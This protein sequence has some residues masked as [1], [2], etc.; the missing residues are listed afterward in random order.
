[1]KAKEIIKII[2]DNNLQKLLCNIDDPYYCIDILEE[3]DLIDEE[4]YEKIENYE[5]YLNK[6][7]SNLKLTNFEDVESV[8]NSD[9]LYTIIHFKNDD[10]YIKITGTYDSYGNG[11]H[12]YDDSVTQVFPKQ[13]TITKYE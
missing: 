3:N 10:I 1:M 8:C 12:D 13:V 7:L 9:D 4:T 11:E 2:R 5:E 6:F